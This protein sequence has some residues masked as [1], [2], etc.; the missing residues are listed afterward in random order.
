MKKRISYYIY[1]PSG[2][3]TALV[4]GN[5]FDEVEKKFINDRIMEKHTNIEQV[6]FLEQNENRLEMAGGEFCANASRCA[7]HY[8][9]KGRK[10]ELNINVSGLEGEMIAGIDDDGDVWCKGLIKSGEKIEKAVTK[11]DR[12]V[13]KIS[14]EGI[15]HL[16]VENAN[17]L[18]EARLE[19]EEKEEAQEETEES[20]KEAQSKGSEPID[21]HTKKY[22]NED[23]NEKIKEL[24]VK[25]IDKY[26]VSDPNAIGVMFVTSTGD[27]IDMKPVV[28]VKKIDTLFYET[29]CSSGSIAVAIYKSFVENSSQKLNIL[30]PSGQWIMAETELK[31]GRI[32]DTRISGVISTDGIRYEMT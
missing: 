29:A 27:V 30:Q 20:Q 31:D 6:G 19:E 25:L 14:L 26:F 17:L 11:L 5:G 4:E 2:N 10:G 23:S 1:I 7:A 9:L 22:S 21:K 28:W 12:G 15:T 16:V 24:A 32:T 8:Y 18:K 13:Y 3:D